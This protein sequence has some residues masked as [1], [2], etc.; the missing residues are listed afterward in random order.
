MESSSKVAGKSNSHQ[1]SKENLAKDSILPQVGTSAGK[2][3]PKNASVDPMPSKPE[4]LKQK[5]V[6]NWPFMEGHRCRINKAG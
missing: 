1:L 4:A 6:I 2:P 5:F 3:I